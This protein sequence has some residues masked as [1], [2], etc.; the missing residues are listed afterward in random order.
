MDNFEVNAENICF[1]FGALMHN[2]DGRIKYLME[3]IGKAQSEVKMLGLIKQHVD[4]DKVME[5]LKTDVAGLQ[6]QILDLQNKLFELEVEQ[7]KET[8]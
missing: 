2:V 6:E 5:M 1:R 8:Q 3:I 7:Q 4:I